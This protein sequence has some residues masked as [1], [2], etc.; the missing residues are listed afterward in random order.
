MQMHC[1]LDKF[2]FTDMKNVTTDVQEYIKKDLFWWLLH[3]L[4]WKWAE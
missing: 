2:V 1:L 4:L 3:K